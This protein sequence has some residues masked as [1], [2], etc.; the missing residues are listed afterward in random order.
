MAKRRKL[1]RLRRV[2]TTLVYRLFYPQVPVIICAKLDIDI[3]AMPANSC[4]SISNQPPVVA[5][6]L[7]RHGR[8]ASIIQNSKSFSI[9][10]LN[11]KDGSSEEAI[12]N[13][14]NTSKSKARDKLKMNKIEYRLE[15]G[16]PIISNSEAYAT[17][18]LQRVI[19]TGDHNL[20]IA[21][22]QSARASQDF[23][24]YWKFRRY[25]PILYLGSDKSK[26]LV[27]L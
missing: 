24:K 8:T 5:L 4:I 1:A 27:T 15:N 13:L 11:F 22:V 6:A 7:F 23:K 16:L 17:C 14:A 2:E 9:N 19:G 21:R 25:D 26:P 12:L 20:F 18:A 10:W 3:A